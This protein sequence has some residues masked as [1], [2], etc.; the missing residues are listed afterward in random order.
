MSDEPRIADARKRLESVDVRDEPL[1]EFWRERQPDDFDF[2]DPRRIVWLDYEL[3]GIDRGLRTLQRL[4]AFGSVNGRAVLDIGAG[5]GGLCLASA[6][7]GAS[8]VCGV[9]YDEARIQLARKWAQCRGLTVDFQQGIAES[10]PFPDAHF[11]VVFLSSVIEHVQDQE[12]TIREMARVLRP[13]GVFFVD[14]P[15]RLSPHWLMSDPHYGIRWVSAMPNRMGAWWVVNV[16]KVSKTYDVGVFPVY[17][18]LV[19]RLRRHGL[20]AVQ[21]DFNS[22]LLSVITRPQD[23]RSTVKRNVLA[24]TR[25]LG[26]NAVAAACM[27]D[28]VPSFAIVGLKAPSSVRRTP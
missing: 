18:T 27:R 21:S 9:E 10:L 25:R 12:R 17:S 16:R 2:S 28:T 15:N 22:Y 20:Q 3:S 11:D 23:V 6:M 24:L 26:I 5:N 8:R 1:L 13:G 19:R 7:S 14:G 4:A